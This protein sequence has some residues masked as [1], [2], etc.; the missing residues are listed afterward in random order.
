MRALFSQP[1]V[2]KISLLSA[3]TALALSLLL[4]HFSLPSVLIQFGKDWVGDIRLVLFT[5]SEPRHRDIVVIGIDQPTLD[6]LPYRSPIY[7]PFLTQ[8]LHDLAYRHKVKAVGLYVLFDRPDKN[9]EID[10]VL[11]QTL[12]NY[13]AHLVIGKASTLDD[14]GKKFQ[15]SFLDGIT[16]G[17]ADLKISA[18]DETVRHIE[19]K[20]ENGEWSF[21]SQLALELGAT[22]LPEQRIRLMYRGKALME[23]ADR[24]FELHSASAVKHL[25][26]EIDWFYDKIVLIGA[27]LDAYGQHR[28]PLSINRG[29]NRL[30]EILIH[31]HALSQLLEEQYQPELPVWVEYACLVLFTLLA[32]LLVFYRMPFWFRCLLAILALAGFW[33]GSCFL[34]WAGGPLMEI[35][36]PT[37]GFMIAIAIALFYDRR[38]LQTSERFLRT[39]F[40]RYLAPSVIEQLTAQPESLKLG[41]EKREL[42]FIFTDVADFTTLAD[43]LSPEQFV[44]IL[45]EYLE[46]MA[47]IALRHDGTI[48]KFV[49]DALFVMFG[50]PLHQPDHAEKAL[51]CALEMDQFAES[52]RQKWQVQGVTVG[53]TRLGVHKGVATVGNFGSLQR[54]DYTAIGDSVNT[55]ARL[56]SANKHLGTRL[57]VSQEV[58]QESD[59][60]HFRPIGELLLKGK[61]RAIM[62][63]SPCFT[64]EFGTNCDSYR[65]AF[66]SLKQDMSDALDKF[67]TLAR[68]WPADGLV[69]FYLHRLKQGERGIRIKL[70]EK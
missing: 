12:L 30:P 32:V 37:M 34:L 35:F 68:D 21:V 67:E 18:I 17:V 50:A 39:A 2:L 38:Y 57:C 23:P 47:V 62:V 15:K 13:P 41:G 29:K 33:G 4:M 5:K 60:R 49:G 10:R 52:F 44:Q 40:A 51:A 56:E 36:T 69:Q 46:G 26:D 3:G 54:F 16:T 22:E 9:P 55:A 14:D 59:F 27:N 6:E 53:V 65:D 7:R 28:T 31:A 64:A 20:S 25:P 8:L 19:M 70:E 42:S 11:R 45:A 43:S 58:L 63:Y 48:D 61:S 24:S 1:G 66:E